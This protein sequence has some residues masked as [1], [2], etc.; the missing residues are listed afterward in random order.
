[1]TRPK[2]SKQQALSPLPPG[3]LKA[4]SW[5]RFLRG[6]DQELLEKLYV[7]MLSEAVRYDRCCAYFSSSVL[8][9]AARGFGKLIERL[10]ALRDKVPKP[11]LRLVVNEEL[12]A[13]DA[14]AL[15]ETGDLSELE[16][17]LQ[18]RFKT[19]K[20]LLEKQ[21]LGMLG[22]LVKHGLLEVRVGVL[23][24]GEG[25]VHAKFGI[26][27]DQRRDSI[28]FSGSGNESAHGLIANYERL[29]VSGSWNDPE[30][31]REYATE[32]E[33][34]WKD[35]HP[36]VHTVSLPEALR[37]KLVR[38]APREP[39][40]LEPSN[41]LARQRASMIWQFICE[42]AFLPEGEKACDH[43][44]M[45]DLWPHQR[46][47]VEEASRAWPDGR[48][49]CDEVGM[50]KTIEAILT[51]RRLHAGRGVRRALLLVPAGLLKQWQAE[52]REKAGMLVPRLEGL[53]QLVWPGGG[54]QKI[55]S[56][57]EALSQQVLL[58]SRETARTENNLPQVLQ[59]DPWDLVLL[60]EAHAARRSK[61][62]EGE[63][64]SPTLLLNLLRELQLRGK[65]R[66]FLLLSATPMQTHPWEPWDLLSVLGEG[67][68]WL[69]DFQS[70]RDYYWTVVTTRNG[71]C[72]LRSAQKAASLILSDTELPPP[73][74][75]AVLP[76]NPA[77]LARLLVFTKPTQRQDTAEW[78]RSVSPLA[79]RMHRNTRTTLRKYHDQGLLPQPPPV[80]IVRDLA[81]DYADPAERDVYTSVRSYIERRFEELECEK[82]GKGFVMTIYGRRASS[83]PLA[84]RRSLE[85]RR[86]GLRRIV[87]QKMSYLVLE[88]ADEPEYLDME[89]LPH[90]AD[91]G[92]VSAAMP[93]DPHVAFLELQEVNRLLDQV[94]SVGARDTKRD[95]FFDIL[96][97]V[98]D[99][100]RAVLVFTE[101]TDTLEY[102]R[103]SL[104]GFYGSALGCYSGAGGQ[105][106]D[107][108]RW[109]S[110]TKDVITDSLRDGKLR[111]L[112]CTDAASEGLNL[113]AA[114]ALINY[115]LP[116]N[117]SRVE[118][119]IGRID[120]IGQ[121][122]PQI[123]LINLFLEHS[124]DDQ[125][126]RALR[127]RCGLFEH[128]VGSMQPVLA[129]ARRMLQKQEPVDL[130][131]LGTTE[132]EIRRD[133]L[134]AEVYL[135][136]DPVGHDTAS[137]MLTRSHLTEALGYLRPEFG[138]RVKQIGAGVWELS[139][140]G[141]R[142][143]T[144]SSN[145]NA[146]EADEKIAPLSPF[147][148]RVGKL[149]ES[150][151]RPGER[152]PLAVGSFQRDAFR[153]SVAYWLQPSG[154]VKLASYEQ[155]RQLV[156][157][158]D[159]AYP[160]PVEWQQIQQQ[161]QQEAQN[162]VEAREKRSR[163]K[164]HAAIQRQLAAARLRLLRELARYLV[165]VAGETSDLSATLYEQMNRD[166]ASAARLKACLDRL[167]GDPDWPPD[168]VRDLNEF[169]QQ[170]TTNQRKARLLGSEI[171]AA[172]EDPRW[173]AADRL[174]ASQTTP[175]P[176]P[177]L[178]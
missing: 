113:Q 48:L 56:L 157:G 38:F 19:P 92:K 96:R 31:Y 18:K 142:K 51:L 84:L 130:D 98:S 158:W 52:L 21:R 40:I 160:D 13:E 115:D 118:Q 132:E 58:M 39:P 114:G 116:W 23:R 124:V 2:T 66:S 68:R 171:D 131:A 14:R 80:R 128:F 54:E 74:G 72:E 8:A 9:A 106:W 137:P 166:I 165:S 57:G 24:R 109:K 32:F 129:R 7:P 59:A 63:F 117:P 135:E 34:L 177:P 134:L 102:L 78:L 105:L 100:G 144:L 75:Q 178:S 35:Q 76:S 42:A 172:L 97:Q 11:A 64:N 3:S 60:D 164:E 90:E 91:S 45:V 145:V 25:I 17:I 126:Y 176:A 46:H 83:S 110:V 94:D 20:E 168:L 67:G 22:W 162:E 87:S 62:E 65:S 26:A 175:S 112:L 147:D 15:T 88:A 155:L 73:P 49:L 125:V 29:E 86:E 133:P 174:P 143:V 71:R 30:R 10:W 103:D 1:M 27:T 127:A 161:A 148:E 111:V 69:A 16:E 123:L 12:T 139:G 101:Y 99:D 152:L 28:V 70:V 107:G 138:F 153:T 36:D 85:R 89:D 121:K 47:V 108:E 156:D 93:Q 61:Q 159:G 43:T 5:P 146:L 55:T 4:R 6:P 37:L 163:E 53:T 167:G 120:R 140:P 149:A 82:P 95:K 169:A 41:A 81:Y 151:G 173:R 170:I 119:R 104:A 136:S 79:R 50:G 122:H 33:Q 150:L 44:A 141:F 154:P 77:D